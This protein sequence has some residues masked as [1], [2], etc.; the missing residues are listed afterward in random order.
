VRD[1]TDLIRHNIADIESV[2][3]DRRTTVSI[4]LK[5]ATA[6]A[7]ALLVSIGAAATSQAAD[8]TPLG[9]ATGCCRM[10]PQ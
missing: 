9:G 7:L 5:S 8:V 3:C 10:L 6:L 4:T 2:N 1:K